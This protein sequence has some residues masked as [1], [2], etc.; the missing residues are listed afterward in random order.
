MKSA[1]PTP[2][3]RPPIG[4]ARRTQGHPPRE[5]LFKM[6]PPRCAIERVARGGIKQLRECH[7]RRSREIRLTRFAKRSIADSSWS[8]FPAVPRPGVG[9]TYQSGMRSHSDAHGAE[10][11]NKAPALR[12]VFSSSR[13]GSARENII[14]ADPLFFYINSG[15]GN[16]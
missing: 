13:S 5:T 6:H 9:E 1:A 2:P 7:F 16:N 3:V 8:D 10:S 11:S 12:T 15:E 14:P 4:V